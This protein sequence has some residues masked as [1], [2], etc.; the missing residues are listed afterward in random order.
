MQ[1]KPAEIEAWLRRPDA[2][3][4]V[5]VHGPDAGL[6]SERARAYAQATGIALDDAF[7]CIRFDAGELDSAPGRLVNELRTL[8]M[9]GGKRLVW[10]RN[11][12]PQKELVEALALAEAG[13]AEALLLIEA[14]DLK[15]ASALRVAAE[16]GRRTAALACYADDSRSLDTLIDAECAAADKRIALDARAA[17][18]ERLG[19]DRLASRGE[20]AKLILFVGERPAI[21]VDDVEAIIG[22]AS[23]LSV[24]AAVDGV[25]AGDPARF[26][27]AYAKAMAAGQAPFVV[28]A[29]AMRQMQ[30]LLLMRAAMDR[31][32]RSAAAAV[33]AAKPP[34]FFARR[35]LV[36]TAL[37]R[38]DAGGYAAAL[39]RLQAA[40][41]ATRRTPELAAETARL[42]L[43][44]IALTGRPAGR[45][46]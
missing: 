31:D 30:M 17:L 21:G 19:G 35:A 46:R 9:F 14:G 2:A 33:A 13:E 32:G 6:V 24:D 12:G 18:K 44:G 5:V 4:A 43:L 37:A 42:A 15:Q 29:A 25:L 1:V 16:A 3:A 22:D 39:D 41:L 10:V 34:V 7:A 20:I 36:E 27:S 11:A 8:G 38:R 23:A 45:N 28:L 40:V 26:D